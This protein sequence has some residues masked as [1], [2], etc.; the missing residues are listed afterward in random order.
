MI[1]I[2]LKDYLLPV[3]EEG[4][5]DR[6]SL[7]ISTGDV[8]WLDADSTH[9][10]HLLFRAL[11]TLDTPVEGAYFFEGRLLDFSNPITLLPLKKSIGFITTRSALISNRSLRE[12]LT[13]MR[14]YG[15]NDLSARVEDET[16]ELCRHFSIADKMDRRPQDM[17]Q[18]DL[19]AAI[20]IREIVK[21][22]S[23]LLMENPENY[24]GYTR[25]FLYD[26]L[27]RGAMDRG[28]PVVFTSDDKNFIDSVSNRALVL[29]MGRLSE[30]GHAYQ[31]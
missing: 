2:E 29:R 1:R 21:A 10:V 5:L 19:R 30:G 4:A 3:S 20:V 25:F 8:C 24:L 18:A 31:V 7:A 28:V 11:T 14:S 15:A 13:L 12:N 23:L 22:S 26:W 6:F 9:A 17:D 27:L 16:F